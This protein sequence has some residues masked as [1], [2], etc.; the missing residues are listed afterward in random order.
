MKTVLRLIDRIYESAIDPARWMDVLADATKHFAARGAQIGNTDLLNAQLSFSLVHGY[1]WSVDHMQRYERLMGEDPRLPYFSAN[2]FR[3]VHCRMSLTDEQLRAS[4][5][6]REVLSVGGVEYSLGVNFVEDGR[7]LSYFLLLRDAS[8][9]PFGQADCD[10]LGTLIP[11]LARALRIQREFDTLSFERTVGFSALDSMALG[12]VIA[13]DRGGVRFTNTLAA[14]L[15]ERG[16]G[17]QL[18]AGVLHGV[19]DAGDDLLDHVG[20]VLDRQDAGAAANPGA[21]RVRRTGSADPYLVVVSTLK[22]PQSHQ[23]WQAS[24]ERLVVLFVRDPDQ[25]QETRPEVLQRLYGLTGSEARLTDLITAGHPLKKGAASLGI[26]EATA[27]QY[28]KQVFRKTGVQRQ[29]D[30]VRKVM[31]LPPA[32]HVDVAGDGRHPPH[33]PGA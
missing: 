29:A 23:A 27:R 21:L 4:R 9:P 19:T 14:R 7:A 28:L 20:R 6:Y 17:L 16:D 26:T 32:I 33:R 11:H 1:D 22:L 3:P 18:C 8:M 2:P 30:L 13:D 12:V 10:K 24:D 15:L 25:A 31:H 5:V